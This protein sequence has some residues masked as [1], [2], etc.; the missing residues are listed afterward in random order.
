[1]I[2]NG[3]MAKIINPVNYCVAF[4]S[5]LVHC[6]TPSWYVENKCYHTNTRWLFSIVEQDY[7]IVNKV[8]E[9]I[10]SGQFFNIQNFS[11]CNNNDFDL[12]IN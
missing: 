9:I 4:H 11:T 8:S 1:M 10:L 3:S 7:N 2:H 5:A 6:G 12:V